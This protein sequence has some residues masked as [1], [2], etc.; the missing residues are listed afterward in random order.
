M[1]DRAKNVV[2]VLNILFCAL[3]V[4]ITGFWLYGWSV[5]IKIFC[6]VAA[7]AGL[8][9]ARCFSSPKGTRF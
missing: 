4:I 5:L 6:Y 7:C 9:A 3:I 1:S 2:F 8:Y